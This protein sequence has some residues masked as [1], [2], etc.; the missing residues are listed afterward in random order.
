MERKWDSHLDAIGVRLETPASAQYRLVEARWRGP[1]E[2]GDKHHIYVRI[3]DEAGK[4]LEGQPFQVKNG[5]VFIERTKGPGFDDYY[6]NF[7]MFAGGRYTLDIPDATSDRVTGLAT[8]L[9]NDPYANTSVVLVFQQGADVEATQPGK[10]EPEPVKPQ[11]PGGPTQDKATQTRLLEL[12]DQA[13]AEIEAA[14]K[15]LEAP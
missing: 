9:P 5:D 11:L 8:G 15:L 13:Q 10:P 7:P 6:G 2:S 12:L 3:L 1:E 4:P 14:R